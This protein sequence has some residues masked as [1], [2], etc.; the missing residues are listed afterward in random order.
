MGDIVIKQMSSPKGRNIYVFI[1]K[2]HNSPFSKVFYI[3]DT[4]FKTDESSAIIFKRPSDIKY[5]SIILHSFWKP[6]PEELAELFHGKSLLVPKQ[7]I[8]KIMTQLDEF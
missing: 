7:T 2:E 3:G 1:K 8:V 6:T 5:F 4:L